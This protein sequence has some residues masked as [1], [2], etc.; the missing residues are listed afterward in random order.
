MSVCCCIHAPV[1]YSRELERYGLEKLGPRQDAKEQL[2]AFLLVGSLP[3][4]FPRFRTIFRSL[5]QEISEV[6]GRSSLYLT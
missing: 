1:E 3:P 2:R 6:L 4:L 5:D